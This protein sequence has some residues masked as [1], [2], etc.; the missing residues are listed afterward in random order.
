MWIARGGF[1]LLIGMDRLHWSSSEGS[2]RSTADLVP[3]LQGYVL[4]YLLVTIDTEEEF[5]WQKPFSSQNRSVRAIDHLP[6][7]QQL[8]DELDVR[9]TY[10]V[11][12]PVAT[13]PA[14]V[15]VLGELLDRGRCEVGAHLHPWVNPPLSEVISGA[16]SYLCNLPLELQ[17]EKVIELTGAI[18]KNLHVHPRT[19]KAG[20]YGLDFRLVP[21]LQSLGYRVDT[22]V[23]SYSDMTEDSGPDF[24]RFA[25]EPFRF[26]APPDEQTGDCL[27]L[28]EV[29]STAG[30]TRR[31]FSWSSR[32]YRFASLRQIRWLR[33]RGILWRS[34]LLRRVVLSPEGFEVRDLLRIVNGLH[35]GGASVL[36]VT[37]HSPSL[38]P[39]NTPYVRNEQELIVLLDRLR[40]TLEYARDLGAEPL[41]MSELAEDWRSA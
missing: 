22:S 24:S 8:L 29:P 31:P 6:Q 11:D 26:E 3:L 30:F 27:S 9:P 2:L 34:R 39:G 41:T 38:Q 17:Q 25:S 12:H 4:L 1:A 7:L 35:R 13:T 15:R 5:D 19:F 37:L 40:R 21:F 18:E 32:A 14:S 28:L 16:N 20:R 23:L 33:L 36:N 10:V